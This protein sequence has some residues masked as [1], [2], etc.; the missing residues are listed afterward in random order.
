MAEIAQAVGLP[1]GVIN[2]I[3]ADRA[4]SEMLVRHPGV[5]KIS[6]TGSTVSGRKIA[7][8]CGDR[9]AR[10]TL[11]L[12]GKSAAV[13]LDDY[14]LETAAASIVGPARSEERLVGK[15]CVSTCRSRWR[16]YDEKTKHRFIYITTRSQ[17]QKIS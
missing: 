15:E 11:E 12:G 6:F 9:I 16:P 1:P 5:D 7:A 10:F 13:I 8:I 14:D 3:T 2:V 4:V 17:E